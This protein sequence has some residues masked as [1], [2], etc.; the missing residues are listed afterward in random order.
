[1]KKYVL[2][3][4]ILFFFNLSDNFAQPTMAWMTCLLACGVHYFTPPAPFVCLGVGSLGKSRLCKI[5]IS[6][7]IE[8]RIYRY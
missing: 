1:M 8:S 6:I 3:L 4:S 7:K 2:I 5:S